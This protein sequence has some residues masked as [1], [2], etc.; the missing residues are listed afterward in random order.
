MKQYSKV[1]NQYNIT[2]K[3][4]D[5]V[6]SPDILFTITNQ[7]AGYTSPPTLTI[8]GTTRGLGATATCTIAG[9]K[10]TSVKLTNK[11]YGFSNTAVTVVL[12]G[13]GFTTAGTITA[14]LSSTA[15]SKTSKN[16]G[17]H[18]NSKRYRFNLNGAFNNVQLSDNAKVTIESVMVPSSNIAASL[19]STFVRLRDTNDNIY[20]SE[21]GMNN[22]PIVLYT[23][24]TIA[25][26]LSFNTNTMKDTKSFRVPRNFLL[27]GY[28]EFDVYIEAVMNLTK[29]VMFDENNFI[30]S[31]VVYEDDFEEST[32]LITAPQVV[33]G[34]QY[35]LYNNFYPN[36]NNNK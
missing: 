35:K 3:G 28:V 10:I 25:N 21:Q 17:P 7:G 34:Q 32:D 16:L 22:N 33:E 6:Y 26:T 31:M 15:Y 1:K 11:G 19:S 4:F 13:G 36:Y 8:A 20:D 29:D 14:V 9:G 12:A 24:N 5:D 18:K 23:S 27:K 30:V 2:F